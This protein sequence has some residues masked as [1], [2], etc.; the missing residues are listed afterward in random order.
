MAGG[1][2]GQTD[3]EKGSHTKDAKA[4]G[5]SPPRAWTSN[6]LDTAG[7]GEGGVPFALARVSWE[8]TSFCIAISQPNSNSRFTDEET[9]SERCLSEVTHQDLNHAVCFQSLYFDLLH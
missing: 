2:P 4:P 9:R 5:G 8:Q 1:T 7:K 6:W 3:G